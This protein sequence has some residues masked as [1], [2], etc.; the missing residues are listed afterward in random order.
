M[1][2]LDA[3]PSSLANLQFS[4]QC[5]TPICS[6]LQ[7]LDLHDLQSYHISF[8]LQHFPKMRKCRSSFVRDSGDGLAVCLL[9]QQQ[10]RQNLSPR[11]TFQISPEELG[12]IVQ[13]TVDAPFHDIL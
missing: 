7:E 12:L 9:H 2:Q 5:V 13:W 6:T 1:D 10:Q 4:P 8:I 11:F 3:D